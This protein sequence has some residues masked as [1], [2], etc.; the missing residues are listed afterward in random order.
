M[1][2]QARTEFAAALN[3][4]CSERGIEPEVVLESIKAAVLAAYKKD[5]GEV[6]DVEV[7]LDS[8]TGEVKLSANGKDLTPPGFGRIAA[9]TAKQVIVQK[10][11]E[12]EKLSIL[13]EFAQKVG[14]LISAQ[15]LR[16]AGS[17][18]IVNLG[19]TE[20]IVPPSEQIPGEKYYPGQRLK[21]LIKEIR[22]GSKDEEIILSRA[23]PTFIAKLFEMEVPEV[24]A[25]SVEIKAIAREPGVRTKIAVYSDKP[26]VDPVGSC[27]GQKGVRVNAVNAEISEEK[28]DVINFSSDIKSFVAA[29]LAPA[30]DVKVDFDKK[31]K[32]AKVSVPDD[33][34]SLAIGTRG[35]NARLAAKLTGVKIVI[36]NSQRKPEAEKLQ[37]K[38]KARG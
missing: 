5:Y 31:T 15:V 30:K 16:I 27:V 14:N 38:K 34:L 35:G 3:Q 33:R 8:A 37:V 7:E 17:L 9:Q 4:I 32:T 25:G 18:V 26:G 1:A 2:I 29:A 23:D 36:T 6:A 12:A 13:S 19:K 10:I 28:I 20:G 11:R 24:A 22:T 21:F